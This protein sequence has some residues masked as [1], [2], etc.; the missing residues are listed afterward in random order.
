MLNRMQDTTTLALLVML[1]IFG[2]VAAHNQV[3]VS[4]IIVNPYYS[5]GINGTVESL[6]ADLSENVYAACF[7]PENDKQSSAFLVKLDAQLHV[8]WTKKYE[9]LPLTSPTIAFSD[10]MGLFTI[11]PIEDFETNSI[12]IWIYEIDVED[13]STVQ[14]ILVDSVESI[15]A[16]GLKAFVA[17]SEQK[18]PTVYISYVEKRAMQR[19]TVTKVF[20]FEKMDSSVLLEKWKYKIYNASQ[21]V[22]SHDIAEH[23]SGGGMYI[24]QISRKPTTTITD[25]A[26]ITM[27]D[28]NGSVLR[29]GS[30][31][32]M[33]GNAKISCFDSDQSGS[34]YLSESPSY[35]HHIALISLNGSHRITKLWSNSTLHVAAMHVL[36]NGSSLFVLA[37]SKDIRNLNGS[38]VP[39]FAVYNY[40]G[41]ALFSKKHDE[42]IRGV[43]RDLK[44]FT[45]RNE[46]ISPAIVLGGY[47]RLARNDGSFGGAQ[48]SLGTYIFPI[49]A[50][51]V[52]NDTA[53]FP[54]SPPQITNPAVETTDIRNRQRTLI[55]GTI[56]GI[57]VVV[58]MAGILSCL[59]RNGFTL[60]LKLS[61]SPRNETSTG[62]SLGQRSVLW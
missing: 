20:K 57:A 31:P 62:G 53:A 7:D 46:A 58:V 32:T 33:T 30:F 35:L 10:A 19:G 60:G 13:G 18:R 24:A 54:G 40:S 38:T 41:V 59:R 61:P 3:A 17:I 27:I 28:K 5:R 8:I 44:T 16:A 12:Q 21:V 26:M 50:F 52:P 23:F 42:N 4:G 14:A 29:T 49:S 22:V 37:T 9:T 15:T 25:S 39:L 56:S 43:Y 51:R 36:Q 48:I 1:S 45:M 55:I 2:C 47:F 11:V 6:A 34:M